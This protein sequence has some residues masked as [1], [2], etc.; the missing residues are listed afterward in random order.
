VLRSY[1]EGDLREL[2]YFAYFEEYVEADSAL[3]PFIFEVTTAFLLELMI[4][5]GGLSDYS[6]K[7]PV[8]KAFF[9]FW[10]NL[11]DEMGLISKDLIWKLV[12]R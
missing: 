8:S 7:E 12:R 6:V 3:L 11:S 2:S 10:Y 9:V 5:L 1:F 4:F